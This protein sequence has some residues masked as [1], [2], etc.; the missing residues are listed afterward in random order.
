MMGDRYS[1]LSGTRDLLITSKPLE[2]F[3]ISFMIRDQINGRLLVSYFPTDASTKMHWTRIQRNNMMSFYMDAC[4]PF[5]KS[6]SQAKKK[7][8]ICEDVYFMTEDHCFTAVRR[9]DRELFL[10]TTSAVPWYA[11]VGVAED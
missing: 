7:N 6:I 8:D 1:S 11:L 3:I 5:F 2:N 10:L 4:A 9:N